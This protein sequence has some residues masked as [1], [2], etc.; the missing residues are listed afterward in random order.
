MPQKEESSFIKETIDIRLSD[1]EQK[2][3]L[4]AAQQASRLLNALKIHEDL[5]DIWARHYPPRKT[6]K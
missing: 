1:Q 6:A 3:R 5:K 2:R 4:L